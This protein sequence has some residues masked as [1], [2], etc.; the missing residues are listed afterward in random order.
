MTE[1]NIEA[2]EPLSEEEVREVQLHY[3]LLVQKIAAH[4]AYFARVGIARARLEEELGEAEIA[5]RNLKTKLAV[6]AGYNDTAKSR[7]SLLK[8]IKRDFPKTVQATTY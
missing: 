6:L 7:V 5:V 4:D 2:I 8:D 3:D 1:I